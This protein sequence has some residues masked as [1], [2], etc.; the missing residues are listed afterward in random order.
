MR[1]KCGDCTIDNDRRQ[2]FRMGVSVHIEPKA[3]DLLW[4]LITERPRA[5]SKTELLRRVWP[6]AVVTGASLTRLVKQLR[7][8]VGDD[9]DTQRFIRT[10]PRFGYAFVGEA[11]DEHDRSP[12]W[13]RLVGREGHLSLS[14]GCNVIGRSTH[15]V[16]SLDDPSVSRRHASITVDG[17]DVSI[18]DLGSKN[19]TFVGS[20]RLDH[21][22]RLRDG[23]RVRFGMAA[24]IFKL[25]AQSSATKTVAAHKAR[26][27]L[28]V[29]RT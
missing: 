5:L 18:E 1:L 27:S 16:R 22:R 25:S 11:G 17:S 3:F 19:G 24:F 12:A 14:Q 23:D 21:G 15:P 6:D 9:A 10:V 13:C 7:G 26:G 4:V 28:G 2:I 8:A 20:E 29:R